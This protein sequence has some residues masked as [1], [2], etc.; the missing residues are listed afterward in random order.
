MICKTELHCN[1]VCVTFVSDRVKCEVCSQLAYI[2]LLLRKPIFFSLLSA[3]Q[4]G[5]WVGVLV[6]VRPEEQVAIL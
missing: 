6:C 1:L 5:L 4:M 2:D 3:L